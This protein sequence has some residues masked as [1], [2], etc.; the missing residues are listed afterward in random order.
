MISSLMQTPEVPHDVPEI[1][2]PREGQDQAAFLR[3]LVRRL[4]GDPGTSDEHASQ[5]ADR[6]ATTGAQRMMSD[7]FLLPLLKSAREDSAPEG[8]FAPGPGER[9]FGSMLDQAIA[10]RILESNNFPVA[11]ALEDKLRASFH[12][13]AG[14]QTSSGGIES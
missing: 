7:A 1:P 12:R 13:V 9:R 6:L 8:I 2:A 10:D 14:L 3:T 4:G 5:A 11:E